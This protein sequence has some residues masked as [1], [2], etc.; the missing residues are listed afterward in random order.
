[1]PRGERPLDEGD[2]PLLLFAADLRQ[3]RTNAGRPSYRE[4]SRRAHFSASTLSDAA[5]GRKLPGLDVT[6]AY[7]RAC[8]GDETAWE[9]R[10]HDLAVAMARSRSVDGPSPYVGL[11]PFTTEDADRFFG[12]EALT[13]TLLDRLGRQPFLAVFGAS[14]EGKSSLLRAGIAAKFANA[15]VC[16]PGPD[17]DAALADALA[18]NPDLLVVDQF[19]EL[20]TLCEDEVQRSA[21]LDALLAADGR[22]VIAVRS[23]FYPHCAQY[24]KL[25]DALTDAQVLLGTMT[26]DELRRAITQPAATVGCTV[27]TALLTTLVAEAAGRSGVLPLVSHA[28]LETW[29]R[30]RG[31]TLT[32][33]GYQAAGGIQGALAQSAEAAYATL[34]E[35]QQ[36]LAKQLL[37]RLS[38]DGTKRPIPRQDVVGEDVLDVL[39]DTRLITVDEDTVEVTHEALFEAWPRLRAWLDEDR[40][41]LRTH[42]RLTDATRT[43]QELG[44]DTDSL[45][46]ATR[47]AETTEWVARAKP[48]LTGAE[49][50]FIGASKARERR[51]SRRVRWIAAGLTALLVATTATAVLAVQQRRE[52]DRLGLVRKSQELTELSEALA[53]SDPVRSAQTALEA[54]ETYPT[55]E[56]RGRLLSAAATRTPGREISMDGAGIG[57]TM[58]HDGAWSVADINGDIALMGPRG[59]DLYDATTFRH[60]K[61]VP[62]TEQSSYVFGWDVAEDGRLAVSEGNGWITVRAG[63]E[64]EPVRLERVGMP[65]GVSF[66]D[67]DRAL[68]VGGAVYDLATRQK[69]F[70]LPV[71]Q[72]TGP[73]TIDGDRTLVLA[74]SGSVAVWD[75]VARHRTGG[76]SIGS[77]VI[78][79]VVL[80]P[81]GKQAAIGTDDG[82]VEVRDVVTGA[83]VATPPRHTGAVTTISIS[84]DG[85]VLTSAG[86][87][88][89]LHLWDLARGTVLATL[90][91]G[92]PVHSTRFAPDG[93]LAIVTRNAL[94]FW[95]ASNIPKASGQMVR[96]LAVDSDGTVLTLDS[97]GVIERRDSTTG[98][99]KRVET[100][101]V[102]NWMGRFSPDRKLVVTNGPLAVR[103]VA[104]GNP[105]ANLSTL[106]FSEQGRQPVALE[107][108]GK[109]L[110]AIGSEVP[111]GVWPVAEAAQPKLIGGL[112]WGQR[113]S[114]VFGRSD[115]EI[116]IGRED[117]GISVRDIRSWEEKAVHSP[118]QR[119]VRAMVLSPDKTLL[120]T[121]DDNGLIALWDTSAWRLVG[122]LRGHTQGVTALEF[123]PDSAR[124]ASGGRDRDVVVWDV[125][126]RASWATLRG[127]N[128]PVTHL[129][130]RPDGAAVVSAGTDAV[131][132]WGLD[133]DQALR[134]IR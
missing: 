65:V 77:G 112:A 82:L 76:F 34:D 17:P 104:T 4:L 67:D 30:R 69:R 101:V 81:G 127:H 130:W 8:Q 78:N 48:E 118:H 86:A 27:E 29:H 15:V 74:S 68:L 90:A 103:E 75:L 1:M 36:R 20:F 132:V 114:A 28:L 97:T 100:G 42:R 23:D 110:L 52:V 119:P 63:L 10:W 35:E 116:V 51:R 120:A 115:H 95:P 117:G 128:Q 66:I 11:N 125:G 40:E 58:Q 111:D 133:V 50:E 87:D 84:P 57:R 53:A 41:G 45:Y 99:V 19:E 124:L 105:V 129:A 83:V 37:L 14:G 92:E 91:V 47:L 85:T 61:T 44:R 80:L 49:R 73:F 43:W 96:A 39:A 31:N 122:E 72:V 108:S 126:A 60:I 64:A 38:S 9:R 21:F 71:G 94:R 123:S 106:G 134:T 6:L 18:R 56:A 16:T 33:T 102:Q 93:S 59:L 70:E 22:R 25:A 26:P 121:G 98:T 13:H 55:V 88:G 131:N 32:L 46:R 79:R 109:S 89:K 107:F 24:P 54:Y 12:R 2:S 113:T 3:L 7:V 5:G 62:V